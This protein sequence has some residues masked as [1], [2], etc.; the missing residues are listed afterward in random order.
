MVTT[1]RRVFMPTPPDR[2]RFTAADSII[3]LII[4]GLP[5]LGIWL[6]EAAPAQQRC[7]DRR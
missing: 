5:A 6:A 1:I 3:V 7:V 2:P 4:V